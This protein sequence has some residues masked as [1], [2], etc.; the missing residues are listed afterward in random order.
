VGAELSLSEGESG[1]ITEA[2]SKLEVLVR[3]VGVRS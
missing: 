3:E 1:R 2:A